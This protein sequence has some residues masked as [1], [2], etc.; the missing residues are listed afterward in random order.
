MELFFYMLQR[1]YELIDILLTV[2]AH[3]KNLIIPNDYSE[4]YEHCQKLYQF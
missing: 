4:E 1:I 3:L 2:I